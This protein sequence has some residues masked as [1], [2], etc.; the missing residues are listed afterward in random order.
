MLD[1][2]RRW[3]LFYFFGQ[4]EGGFFLL[5]FL[6]RKKV[7]SFGGYRR[8][9]NLVVTDLVPVH[10]GPGFMDSEGKAIGLLP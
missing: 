4:R 1:W 5:L 8:N 2:E 7:D 9:S 10:F 3:I 6:S